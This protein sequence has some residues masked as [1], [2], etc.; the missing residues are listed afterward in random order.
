[1]SSRAMSYTCYIE[2]LPRYL[3]IQFSTSPGMSGYRGRP[4]VATMK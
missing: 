1:M 3:D 4:P 2:E